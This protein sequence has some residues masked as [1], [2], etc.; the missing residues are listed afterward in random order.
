MYL[1]FSLVVSHH[2]F[3]GYNIG[4]KHKLHL[5]NALELHFNK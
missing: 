4:C 3:I 5:E 1:A 2:V